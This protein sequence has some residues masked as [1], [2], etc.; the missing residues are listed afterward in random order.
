MEIKKLELIEKIVREV[1]NEYRPTNKEVV[2]DLEIVEDV[3]R[4]LSKF[5]PKEAELTLV[6]SIAKNTQLRN[7]RDADLFVL[8]PKSFNDKKIAELTLNASKRL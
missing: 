5:L 8:F 1:A 3:K 4:R 2:Q 6:G 7:E